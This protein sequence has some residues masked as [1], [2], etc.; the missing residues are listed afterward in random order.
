MAFYCSVSFRFSGM[1]FVGT[2]DGV[3]L[4]HLPPDQ[5]VC[6][7]QRASC[8]DVVIRPVRRLSNKSRERSAANWVSIRAGVLWFIVLG[9]ALS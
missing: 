3:P 2:P 7:A 5:F 8:C 9:N 4:L 1:A 6:C